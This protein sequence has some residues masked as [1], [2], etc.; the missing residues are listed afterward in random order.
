MDYEL[1]YDDEVTLWQ[2]TLA[3]L[4]S[5]Q[6]GVLV[7]LGMLSHMY[8]PAD[9]KL[10]RVHET[11]PTR[12]VLGYDYYQVLPQQINNE[13]QV[14]SGQSGTHTLTHIFT[15]TDHDASFDFLNFLGIV[16][17]CA[18]ASPETDFRNK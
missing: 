14:P 15:C 6:P 7:A 11:S 8:R 1:R 2:G 5:R 12:V 4:V 3:R 9:R 16:E 13:L 18:V 10:L 17:A